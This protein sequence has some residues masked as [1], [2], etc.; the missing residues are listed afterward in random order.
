MHFNV[1]NLLQ[2][3]LI[4]TLCL[5]EPLHKHG[6]RLNFALPCIIY[7]RAMSDFEG[8]NEISDGRLDVLLS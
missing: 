3:W 2:F 4:M 8:E 5:N 6:S 7:H 1:L